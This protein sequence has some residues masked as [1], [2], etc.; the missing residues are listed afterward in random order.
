[1][2][3]IIRIFWTMDIGVNFLTGFIRRDGL[4]EVRFAAIGKRY[5]K[6]WL[7]DVCLV[8][9]DWSEVLI[10]ALNSEAS[11]A[12]MAKTSRV[13]RTFRTLRFVKMQKAMNF[14]KLRVE[15]ELLGL[16]LD[17]LRA[18]IVMFGWV[19]VATCV[20]CGLG[21]WTSEWGDVDTLRH[22]EWNDPVPGH[23]A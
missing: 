7:A 21:V 2:G 13:I 23:G 19:H 16:V 4:T 18:L 8:L 3:W 11:I 12:R 6:T 1:M 17:I 20:W 14:L 22:V 15:S 10:E 5:A 9:S